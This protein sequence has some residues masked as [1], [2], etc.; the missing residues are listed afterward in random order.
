[1][2]DVYRPTIDYCKD[3]FVIFDEIIDFP[4]DENDELGAE[5]Y[6]RRR[7]QRAVFDSSVCVLFDFSKLTGSELLNSLVKA[8]AVSERPNRVIFQAK[9]WALASEKI[10]GER[11]NKTRWHF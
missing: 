6:K 8:Q 7:E 1:M 2:L 3:D 10:T 5:R 9:T 4:S 11:L